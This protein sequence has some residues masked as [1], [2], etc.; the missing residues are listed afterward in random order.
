V[1]Q[2]YSI[3]VVVSSVVDNKTGTI[4][5]LSLPFSTPVPTGT[6]WSGVEVDL[7]QESDSEKGVDIEADQDT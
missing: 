7:V 4:Q 6:E 3:A 1:P 5:I 2:V